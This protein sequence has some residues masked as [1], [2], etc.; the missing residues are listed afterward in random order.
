MSEMVH[1]WKRSLN[2]DQKCESGSQLDNTWTGIAKLGTH[3][4][5]CRQ[6]EV[7]DFGYLELGGS[8]PSDLTVFKKLRAVNL[9]DNNLRGM[10]SRYICV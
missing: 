4:R 5:R 7:L 1:R 6:V 3:F 8:L 2:W 9:R 10:P